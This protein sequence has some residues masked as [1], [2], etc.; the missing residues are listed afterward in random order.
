MHS[1]DDLQLTLSKWPFYV[2][3][4]SLVATALA[5]GIL[6]KW[7]LTEMQV[8]AC[9][10]AVA[11]GAGLFVLPYVV[12]Y[13]MRSKEFS[14]DRDDRLRVLHR[15]MSQ[16]ESAWRAYDE[17]LSDLEGRGTKAAQAEDVQVLVAAIDR[18]L[19]I[20]DQT[21]VGLKAAIGALELKLEQLATVEAPKEEPNRA[22]IEALQQS[23]SDLEGKLAATEADRSLSLLEERIRNLEIAK[24]EPT[25]PRESRQRRKPE[26]RLLHR[27]I[28]E[29]QDTASS[30]MS[31]IIES[32]SRP[33]PSRRQPVAEPEE[34]KAVVGDSQPD[35]EIPEPTGEVAVA[36]VELAAPEVAE[37]E[38]AES[39]LAA[40]EVA[41]SEPEVSEPVTFEPAAPEPATSESAAAV[42]ATERSDLLFES[43]PEVPAV[44]KG[45]AKKKD[46][47]LM[48]SVFLGIGNK[49]YLRGSG[50]GLSWD[51]GVLMDFQEIGKWRWAAPSG[52]DEPVEV[53]IFRNDEDPDLQGKHILLPGQE[54]EISP[55]F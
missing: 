12:E 31:R 8:A 46:S 9:V 38:V 22:V 42:S 43:L 39:E 7:Q 54:L 2:G 6:G 4:V 25:L 44:K 41:E 53:Q 24:T 10:I 52:M 45:R 20:Q 17:R 16:L 49:P 14:D 51:L 29:K 35:A 21:Q 33:N 50:A 15:H 11:L 26:A 30:A 13:Y 28:K 55:R 47:V 27:A 5:I 37:S 3:D 34:A 48:V 23:L 40:P 36:T 19:A 1:D 18:K 32:K